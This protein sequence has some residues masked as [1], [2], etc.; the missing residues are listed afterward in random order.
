RQQAAGS[1]Q[2][3]AGSRQQAAGSRQ[4]AAGSRQPRLWQ[5]Y[6]LNFLDIKNA[7]NYRKFQF[8]PENLRSY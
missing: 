3:A 6:I 1:R 8:Y 4:Q 5:T 2:Q 7:Q